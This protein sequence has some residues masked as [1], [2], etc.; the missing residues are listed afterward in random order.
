VKKRTRDIINNMA[1]FLAV[2][3]FAVARESAE[4]ARPVLWSIIILTLVLLVF[5]VLYTVYNKH[6]NSGD[7]E[8][9]GSD[10][11]GADD[12]EP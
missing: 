1:F 10:D 4:S 11:P 8:T 9:G 7:T 3:V 6:K 2:M 12:G 5:R